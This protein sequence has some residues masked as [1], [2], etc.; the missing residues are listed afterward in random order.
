MAYAL[1]VSNTTKE[2]ST[3]EYLKAPFLELDFTIFMKG[4]VFFLKKGLVFL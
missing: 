2:Q 3:V 4:L 1:P